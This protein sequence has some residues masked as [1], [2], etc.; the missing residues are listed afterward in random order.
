MNIAAMKATMT[1][2]ISFVENPCR[3]V[4]RL[5]ERVGTNDLESG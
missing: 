4:V 1:C 5:P 3:N 2:R